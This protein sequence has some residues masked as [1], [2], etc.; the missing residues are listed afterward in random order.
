[1]IKQFFK[2]EITEI[3]PTY[4]PYNHLQISDKYLGK[5]L[6]IG[7]EIVSIVCFY[8]FKKQ[9][10]C[11]SG[12]GIKEV[13]EYYVEDER[14]SIWLENQFNID[15]KTLSVMYNAFDEIDKEL[16]CKK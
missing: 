10:W 2:K 15:L 4:S 8:D 11:T 12:A 9:K 1:M 7:N 14:F 5:G 13:L 6:T 3:P 16:L